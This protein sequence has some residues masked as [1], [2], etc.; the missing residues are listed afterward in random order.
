VRPERG[1]SRVITETRVA[2]TSGEATGALLRYWRAIRLGSG[3][4]LRIEPDGSLQRK[5][6]DGL[7]EA[8]RLCRFDTAEAAEIRAEGSAH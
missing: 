5:D 7:E 2:G 8:V 6:E 4:I 1:G 3:A